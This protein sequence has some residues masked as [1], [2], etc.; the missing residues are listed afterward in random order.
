MPPRKSKTKSKP[1]SAPSR[2]KYK[3]RTYAPRRRN[4]VRSIENRGRR[5]VL[6]LLSR[7]PRGMR[8]NQLPPNVQRQ[9]MGRLTLQDLSSLS[10]TSGQVR[11]TVRGTIRGNVA[12]PRPPGSAPIVHW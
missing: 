4:T 9:I 12:R 7:Y 3:P 10:R 11:R 1:K 8:L 6:S 5:A 2:I